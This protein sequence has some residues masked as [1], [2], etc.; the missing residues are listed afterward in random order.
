M[1]PLPAFDFKSAPQSTPSLSADA[2]LKFGQDW[3][4]ITAFGD[5][6]TRNKDWNRPV[7]ERYQLLLQGYAGWGY[8]DNVTLDG[9]PSSSI[10]DSTSA[11]LVGGGAQ[12]KLGGDTID[13][14]LEGMFNIS[15]RGDVVAFSST[16]AGAVVAVDADLAVFELYGGPFASVFLGRHLR[17]YASAGPQAQWVDYTQFDPDLNEDVDSNASGVGTYAR[18][19]LEL[20]LESRTMIGLGV[21]WSKWSVD[22]PDDRG[23]LDLEGLQ[24][25]FTVTQGL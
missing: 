1:R 14:G 12:W 2:E 4:G 23:Q 11:G 15:G 24:Y 19:G 3:D 13:F 5:P 8:Y 16:S 18:V 9:D 6:P 20:V 21:R 17:A 10:D 22:L 7:W 25:L